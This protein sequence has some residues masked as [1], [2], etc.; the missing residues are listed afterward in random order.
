MRSAR[1]AEKGSPQR[2]RKGAEKK[3]RDFTAENAQRRRGKLQDLTA[4]NAQRRREKHRIF[5]SL[6]AA[7]V[8]SSGDLRA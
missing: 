8:F 6:P 2:T 1:R 4:A 7:H 5:S 3:L